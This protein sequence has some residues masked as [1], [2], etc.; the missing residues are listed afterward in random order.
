MCGVA[1]D[2]GIYSEPGMLQDSQ[3]EFLTWLMCLVF[4]VAWFYGDL[5]QLHPRNLIDLNGVEAGSIPTS[6]ESRFFAVQLNHH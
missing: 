6:M 3:H 5:G 4:V 1:L 2:T